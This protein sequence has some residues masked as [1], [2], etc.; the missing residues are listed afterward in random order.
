MR[1]QIKK[2]TEEILNNLVTKKLEIRG[3]PGEIL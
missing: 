1:C 2:K 3:K